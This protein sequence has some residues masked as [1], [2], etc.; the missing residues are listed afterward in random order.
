MAVLVNGTTCDPGLAMDRGTLY[1]QS[2]FETIALVGGQPTLLDKHLTRLE[3]GCEKLSIPFDIN[4]INGNID[5]SLS[6]LASEKSGI[7]RLALTMGAG[8]RGY[9]NPDVASPNHIYSTHDYPVYPLE[10]FLQGVS[11]G[12]S[13]VRLAHQPLLAG[14]KHGNRLEQILARENWEV[15]WDEGL[16]MDYADNVI[17]GTQSNVI[18]IKGHQ[19]LTPILD[20]C[21][22]EGV[23]KGWVLESLKEAGFSCEAVRL[24]LAD[25]IEADEVLLTNSVI[26][27]WPV[28]QFQT[29]CYTQFSTSHW[30]I[31]KLHEHEIIPRY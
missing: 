3:V 6:N 22:V 24:S 28:R 15:D 31:E 14:I 26:G 16:L 18:I 23:M 7:L 25:I 8:G 2:V 9:A 20:Q 29:R 11:L 5:K 13:E 10:N 30:L 17:E 1:G 12:L 21:G 4:E 19:A 27:V